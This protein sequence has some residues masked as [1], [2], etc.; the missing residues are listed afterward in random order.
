MD[1]LMINLERIGG[2]GGSDQVNF[3][4]SFLQHIFVCCMFRFGAEAFLEPQVKLYCQIM[5]DIVMDFVECLTDDH[6]FIP[7]STSDESGLFNTLQ[8]SSVKS[9]PCIVVLDNMNTSNSQCRLPGL[10]K[11]LSSILLKRKQSHPEITTKERKERSGRLE[12]ALSKHPYLFLSL[13]LALCPTSYH[14]PDDA[15]SL[16]LNF[17]EAIQILSFLGLSINTCKN[18]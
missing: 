13:F 14:L 16:S 18:R 10:A 3:T 4:E 9:Y 2:G 1:P 5:L 7:T 12:I 17:T 15:S 6:S 8:L 11:S